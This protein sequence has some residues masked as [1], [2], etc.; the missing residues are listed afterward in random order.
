MIPFDIRIA[1]LLVIAIGYALFDVF[2][3]RNVPDIFVYAFVVVAAV[4][5]LTYDMQ[6]IYVSLIMV[7]GIGCIGYLLFRKGLMGAGDFL[8]FITI[9][10]ILPIQPYPI[11]S[12]INQLGLPFIFSVFVA[13]G[14]A[15]VLG[16]II[17]YLGVAKAWKGSKVEPSRLYKG[18][19]IFAAYLALLLFLAY[20]VGVNIVSI[21]LVLLM[22]IAS[23]FAIIFEKE[24]NKKMVSYVYP[25]ELIEG[26]MLATNFM[27][28]G[29][30][31]Y[32]NSRSKHFGRLVTKD[33]LKDIKSVKKKLP[34]YTAGVPLALFTLVGIII[35][36]LIGN[37]LL[38]VI[39]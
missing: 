28:S 8:E 33:L 24:I 15:A 23:L 25:K 29:E 22:A 7:F 26:D 30:I 20:F 37:L 32:F 5:M 12:S 21:S 36:L 27:K 19:G 31:K 4:I 10:M 18:L 9:S 13:T 17:Y 11:F 38:Y 35:S 3:K 34:V 39:I 6:T 16:M 2:N 14:Y 1:I